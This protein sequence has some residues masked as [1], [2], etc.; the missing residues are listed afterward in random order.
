MGI[1]YI[2]NICKN[3]EAIE[4]TVISNDNEVNCFRVGKIT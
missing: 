2:T 3:F 1:A 4:S